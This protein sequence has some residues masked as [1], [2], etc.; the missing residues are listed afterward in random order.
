MPVQFYF[1]ADRVKALAPQH[2]E[3]KTKEP[4]ASLLRGDVKAALEGGDHGLMELFMATHTGMTTDEFAQLVK[5]WIATAKHPHDRQTLP[6]HDLSADA[7]SA[8]LSARERLQELHRLRRRHRVH[9]PVGGAGLWHP[10]GT[11]RRQQH[12]D[13]VRTARRQGR[14]RA[15]AGA[16]LQRRQGRQ[17]RRHQPAH[18]PPAH[19]RVRQLRRRP[20]DAGI[21]AGRQRRAVRA[22]RAARRRGARIC[23]R[24][25]ARTCRTSNTVTSRPRSKSMR[26]RTAGPSSA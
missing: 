25:R 2:P 7:R 26:R 9:A 3:W 20:A 14:A 4:F 8:R 13:E 12:E 6:R 5:D 16:E 15:S 23:L 22:A 10:A 1:V 21:H 19:R 24:P 17:A 11:G 18:R